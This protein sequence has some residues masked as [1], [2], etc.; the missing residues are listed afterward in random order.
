MTANPAPQHTIFD[1]GAER[2][3]VEADADRPIL[4]DAFEVE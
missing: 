1:I 2:S 3:I 4:S